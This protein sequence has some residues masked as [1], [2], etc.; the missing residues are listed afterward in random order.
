MTIINKI[1]NVFSVK[2]VTRYAESAVNCTLRIK[3]KNTTTNHSVIIT[4]LNGVGKL[5]F[6]DFI[7]KEETP[8]ELIITG[9]RGVMWLGQIF[10]TTKDVQNYTS[11]K[12]N[13][14]F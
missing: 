1:N 2:I 8:Y 3:G 11:T 7:P 10:F 6:S 5:T 9:S 12:N 13:L 14:R 4:Y